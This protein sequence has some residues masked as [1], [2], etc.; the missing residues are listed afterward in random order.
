MNSPLRSILV[1]VGPG[2]SP[3]ALEA[4][5]ALAQRE[6]AQLTIL[7]AV[8]RPSPFVSASPVAL[9][10]DAQ[11]EASVECSA[12]LRTALESVPADV[13]VTGLRRPGP[14]RGA[15][16]DELRDGAYDLVVVGAGRRS[17]L[18][19]AL[20]R[21]APSQSSS[22]TLIAAPS[23]VSNSFPK[24]PERCPNPKAAWSS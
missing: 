10:F 6:H 14:A 4:A 19:R 7:A 2:G 17:R 3:R 1:G 12:R 23:Q 21:R 11:Y 15:L 22:S 20:L 8:A 9:P 5:A 24:E 16:L 18:A 13:S